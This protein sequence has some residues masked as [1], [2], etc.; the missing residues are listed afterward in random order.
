MH[1]RTNREVLVPVLQ[2]VGGV[3]ERRQTL[4]VLGNL[5]IL[6]SE[7]T[8]EVSG[9]DLEVEVRAGFD[10]DV[11]AGGEIT[12]PARKLTDICRALPEG[13]DITLRQDKERFQVL[14]G[15]SRFTLSTLP[16]GDFPSMEGSSGEERIELEQGQLK[17]LLDRTAFAMAHQDVRY[18]L[19][20]LLLEVRPDRLVAV[21]TDGHRLA[22]VELQLE[23]DVGE[24]LQVIVPRKTVLELGR[25]LSGGQ[26]SVRVDVGERS[27]RAVAD[28]VVLTS[29]LVDGRYPEYDRVIPAAPE[30]FAVM[31]RELLR[32]ALQ[33]TS[34]LSNEKYKGVRLHFES[35]VLRLQAH[36]PEQEEAEEEIEIEYEGEPAAIGFNVGYLLDVLNVLGT[37]EVRL[38]FSDGNS[39]A[40]LTG[41]GRDGEIYVVMPMRL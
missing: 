15:R 18:Y 16:A 10:A 26:S 41:G 31:D 36:N 14:A 6:A 1:I 38:A 7:G 22:K 3:V 35:G 29:K 12:V 2:K 28:G 27:F 39:S 34:I 8:V 5:L 40:V 17:D 37:S 33:R 11:Q 9:T 32:Q 4:P 13:A 24:E 30:R 21:A 19:N 20:G 23:S 25:L